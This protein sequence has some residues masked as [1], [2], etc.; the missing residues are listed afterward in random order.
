MK[1]TAREKRIHE[2]ADRWVNGFYAPF[3]VDSENII[4]E[5]NRLTKRDQRRQDGMEILRILESK[6]K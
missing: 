2:L 3:N 4:R 5:V 6:S 1:W